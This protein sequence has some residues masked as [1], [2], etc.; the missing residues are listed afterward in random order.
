MIKQV[1]KNKDTEIF[2]KE[3]FQ[4]YKSSNDPYEKLIAY[5]SQKIIGLISYSIIY[6]RS[7]INYIAVL[8]EYQKKG[9]A[10]KLLDYAI[11]DIKS[12]NCENIS[13]EVETNNI[14]AI[15]LYSKFNFKTKTI[16]KNYYDSKNAY[17]MVKELR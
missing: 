3:N 6:E 16:R 10:T 12:N 4:N 13:L 8:K 2:L 15:N 1:E 17:L 11:K 9:I 7:E 14:A 5:T